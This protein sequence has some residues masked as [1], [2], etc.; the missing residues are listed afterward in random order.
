MGIVLVSLYKETLSCYYRRVEKDTKY[1]SGRNE[2]KNEKCMQIF[3]Y[4]EFIRF[5]VPFD[6]MLSEF[7]KTRKS[8]KIHE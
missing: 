7:G 5:Q 8:L 6:L 3:L 1:I 2:V 4:V